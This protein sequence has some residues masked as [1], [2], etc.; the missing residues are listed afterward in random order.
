MS[1]RD[2]KWLGM[3]AAAVLQYVELYSRTMIDASTHA[4]YYPKAL[5]AL[6]W[7]RKMSAPDR[8]PP[9]GY[10][11]VTRA[12]TPEPGCNTSWLLALTVDGLLAGPNLES[13]G[14]NGAEVH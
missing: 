12:S 8:M 13:Y 1:G 2:D 6:S 4:A 7:L 5:A 9:D 11:P 14:I 10:I 3:A